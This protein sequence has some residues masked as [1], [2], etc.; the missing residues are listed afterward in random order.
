MLDFNLH[1]SQFCTNVSQPFINIIMLLTLETVE[2]LFSH[3]CYNLIDMEKQ[4]FI[5]CI[6][7]KQRDEYS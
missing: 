3:I 2:W 1:V 5:K 4:T 7:G 6:L